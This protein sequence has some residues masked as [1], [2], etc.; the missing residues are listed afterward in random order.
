MRRWLW[1]SWAGEEFGDG[2][3]A[4]R[5]V[6]GVLGDVPRVGDDDKVRVGCVAG[7][8]LGPRQGGDQV[9]IAGE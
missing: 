6:A 8:V 7:F 5:A 2:C 3:A 4:C 1:V 9:M